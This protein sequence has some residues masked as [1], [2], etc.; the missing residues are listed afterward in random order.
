[1]IFSV[2]RLKREV[3]FTLAELVITIGIMGVVAAIAVPQFSEY[4]PISRVSGA[5]K[6]LCTELQAAKMRA[7]SENNNYVITF[8]TTNSSYK[9][10]DD[11]NSNGGEDT[12]ESIKI[13]DIEESYP[14]I[15]YGYIT[16]TYN[17]SG[18]TL[19]SKAVTFTGCPPSL[20]FKPTGLAKAGTAYLIPVAETSQKD[21]QRAVTVA[22]TGRVRLYRHT[23]TVWE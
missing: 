13:V 17:T 21:R 19:I 23:G 1:M 8:N 5:A 18:S 15:G 12:G 3:G 4:L 16:G 7:I 14:G 6:E 2:A 22:I 10:H 11:D 20:T 9:I